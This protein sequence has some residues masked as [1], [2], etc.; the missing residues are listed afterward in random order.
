MSNLVETGEY[1]G[2][3]MLKLLRSLDDE[4]PFQFGVSKAKQL[5][6]SMSDLIAFIE[7]GDDPDAKRDFKKEGS[8]Y[9]LEITRW[10]AQLVVERVEAVQAWVDEQK[11]RPAATYTGVP[12]GKFDGIKVT[13]LKEAS[14]AMKGFAQVTVGGVM[15]IKGFRIIMGSNGLFV[16]MPQRSKRANPDDENGETTYE[17]I[18]WAV[19]KEVKLELETLIL[20]AYAKAGS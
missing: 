18:A 9:P 1:Q 13:K 4:R 7:E 12:S 16:S 15:F 10:Q 20:E 5:L 17:D 19:S 3:A 6:E 2:N 11:T 8:K 14:G